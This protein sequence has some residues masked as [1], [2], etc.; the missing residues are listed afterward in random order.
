MHGVKRR[1]SLINTSRIDHI[2]ENPQLKKRNLYIHYGDLSDY[3]NI[4][5]LIATIKPDEIYNLAAARLYISS[6]LMVA[7][8]L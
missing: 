5:R 1:S 6:G 4:Y 8:S 7:I 2:Y 3:G